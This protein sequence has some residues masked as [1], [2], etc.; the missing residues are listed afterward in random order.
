M[1]IDLQYFQSNT[2]HMQTYSDTLR[3]MVNKSL[4]TGS[5]ITAMN[6]Y[7]LLRRIN[8]NNSLD[9]FAAFSRHEI[10]SLRI[11]FSIMQKASSAAR[12]CTKRWPRGVLITK[13][14]Y[15][16]DTR[17]TKSIAG[18]QDQKLLVFI[19]SHLRALFRQDWDD[20]CPTPLSSLDNNT[21]RLRF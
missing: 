10:E 11:Y 9:I 3:E 5:V 14:K 21:I 4:R 2:Q 15:T 18:S 1:V 7:D 8:D 12:I 20:A 17:T 6:E 13:H 19:V 16:G